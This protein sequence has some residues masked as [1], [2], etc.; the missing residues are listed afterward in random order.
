MMDDALF[1]PGQF[2]A[3][4][5]LKSSPIAAFKK[6]IRQADTVLSQRFAEGRDIHQLIHERAWV[7]D[8]ILQQAWAR[9]PC[10]G[11]AGISLLAVG[12][13]GRGELHPHS[14]I[15]LLILLRGDVE[16]YRDAIEAFL[17]LLWDIGLEV[18]QSVRSI[19]ECQ[20]EAAAD[21]TVITNLMESRTLAGDE[22]LRQDMMQAIDTSHM[23]TTPS[24]SAPNVPSSR[25]AMPSST[26]PNTTSNPTSKAL[27]AACVTS[28]PSPGSPCATLAPT[29][30]VSWC[31]KVF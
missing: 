24:F 11:D 22:A 5:A 25:H 31:S 27:R 17:L 6:A 23:W 1:D 28:R 7:T 10:A 8:Q 4:L 13:Y 20:Q 12:G 14:D 15:D 2:Q 30:C 3:E 26:I 19:E 9:L 29:T 21:I 16:P 18:G